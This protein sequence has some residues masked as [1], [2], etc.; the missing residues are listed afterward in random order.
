MKER[1]PIDELYKNWIE[2]P[3]K[4]DLVKHFRRHFS[5]AGGLRRGELW[6]AACGM[7]ESLINGEK[8]D[9]GYFKPIL[10][11]FAVR[12]QLRLADE[13]RGGLKTLCYYH[14]DVTSHLRPGKNT[15]D[16][17]LGPGYYENFEKADLDPNFG[18]GLAK[19]CF[20]LRFEY[21]DRIEY[22]ESDGETEV[23]DSNRSSMLFSGDRIDYTKVEDNWRPVIAAQPYSGSLV[24]PTVPADAVIQEYPVVQ[25]LKISGGRLYDF[26][27]NHTGGIQLRMHGPRGTKVRILYAECLDEDGSLN[28]RTGAWYGYQNGKEIRHILQKSELILSG[29]LDEFSPLFCFRCYRYVGIFTDMPIEVLSISS[30]FLAVPFMRRGNYDFGDA[31]LNR[32]AEVYAHTQQCASHCGVPLDC[33]HREKLPYTGDGWLTAEA[34]LYFFDVERFYDKWLWDILLAQGKSGFVPYTAPYLGGG[35]GYAWGNAIC[36]LPLILYRFTGKKEYLSRSF[37][38]MLRWVDYYR[39]R[40]DKEGRVHGTEETWLLGDWL[41]PEFNTFD[42]V[43]MSTLCRYRAVDLTAQVSSFLGEDTGKLRDEREN[44][45]KQINHNYYDRATGNYLTGR[46]GENLLPI[47]YGIADEAELPKIL[48]NIRHLYE[49]KLNC[50]PDTGIMAT[51]LLFEVLSRYGMEELALRILRQRDGPSFLHMIE[52]ETTLREHWTP[53]FPP[54]QNGNGILTQSRQEV[55]HCH[56][57]FGAVLAWM[58]KHIIGLDLSR[59]HEKRIYFS[60]A[61]F[62]ELPV[63]SGSF[64]MQTGITKISYIFNETLRLDIM[65]PPGYIGICR[66]RD[67]S[68]VVWRGKKCGKEALLLPPGEHKLEIFFKKT[69]KCTF[70]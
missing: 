24:P 56:P 36:E 7:F 21:G 4:N 34:A 59:L 49:D 60:P 51:P 8:T 66:I 29:G 44:L 42:T 6:I 52:G 30:L 9:A 26:G 40:A 47:A 13:F 35:G 31:E 14:F 22:C 17:L 57:M 23:C 12:E 45:R 61:Y 19:L 54:Y 70:M 18:Y 58:I 2:S 53:Y 65:V 3:H 28:L 67:C 38:G 64:Q 69:K 16:I 20:F 41:S 33:P 48:E 55:S 68:E 25:E 11:D 27:A 10:T 63:A 15:L 37:A 5:V 43:F 39:S 50:H 32:F 62:R 1:I 46:Q